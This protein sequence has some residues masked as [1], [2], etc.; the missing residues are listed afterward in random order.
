MNRRWILHF[1][2]KQFDENVWGAYLQ[3]FF[4]PADQALLATL[5][6]S[7]RCIVLVSDDAP[8]G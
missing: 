3:A 1:K 6:V 5:S 7:D 8:P 4:S 2:R